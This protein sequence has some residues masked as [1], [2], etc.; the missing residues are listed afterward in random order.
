MATNISDKN[1][2]NQLNA[3]LWEQPWYQEWFASKGIDK[4]GKVKLSDQQRKELQ[5]LVVQNGFLDPS[6]GHIDPAGNV[7]DFHGWKGLPTAAKIA[8]AAGAAAAT[9]GAAGAFG[10]TAAIAPEVGI[11]GLNTATL[12]SIPGVTTGLT[13]AASIAPSV[14]IA[15]LN[16]GTLTSIPGVTT[17]TG[18]GLTGAG[19]GGSTISRLLGSR[20]QNLADVGKMFQSFANDEANYRTGQ[21]DSN[22][23]NRYNY[24]SLLGNLTQGY[25]QLG[26]ASAANRRTDESDAMKKLS[27][28]G[29]IKSGG[30]PFDA[31]KVQLAGGRSLP[32]FNFPR[33]PITDEM[34]TGAATLEEQMLK[35]LQPGGSF[36][37]T[38]FDQYKP[39]LPEDMPGR[40]VGEQIGRWGSLGTTGA[41]V[42]AN[43]L[44]GK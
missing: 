2:R 26:L 14:G 33:A 19:T 28:T 24:D 15:G 29:Y 38:P 12:T 16:T 37:P 30:A 25:D 20:T 1:Q 6:D 31:S 43:L 34:K 27:Q 41:G 40:G 9:A 32:S 10:G 11:G 8:I 21:A 18:G 42:I 35:R 22:N 17:G 44:G 36:S 3:A 7:S 13:G 23:R 39:Q 5:A 4:G